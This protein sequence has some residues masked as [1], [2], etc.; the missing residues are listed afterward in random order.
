MNKLKILA[1]AICCFVTA[2]WSSVQGMEDTEQDINI[3]RERNAQRESIV[4]RPHDIRIRIQHT[5][6][7]PYRFFGKV[8]CSGPHL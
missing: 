5:D 3:F 8:K 4:D 2:L 7:P 1:T 6:E